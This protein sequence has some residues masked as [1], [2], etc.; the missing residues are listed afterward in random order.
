MSIRKSVFESLGG[1]SS[2]FKGWGFEDTYFGAC[3]I[4]NGNFVIPVLNTGVYHINHPPR[5]GSEKK[6]Q[7]ELVSNLNIYKNLINQN[8]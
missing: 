5:S 4:A 6:K 2:K 3:A 8:I 7:E 1:F